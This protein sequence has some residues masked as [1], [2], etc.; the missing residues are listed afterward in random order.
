M[1]KAFSMIELIF[2]IVILGILAA[3]A[4][5]K[6]MGTREDAEVAKNL[7][8]IGAI[9]TE[10]PTYV[11][12]QVRVEDNLSKMSNTLANLANA[13]IADVSQPKKAIIKI[14]EDSDCVTFELVGSGNEYNL[15]LTLKQNPTDELCKR[16]QRNINIADYPI[17][18]KGELVRF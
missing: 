2:V 15:T 3:V 5:P 7:Q 1:Q 13:G 11:F 18:I 14:G 12:S 9:A 4:I 8:Y 17:P 6:M 10:I 16:V